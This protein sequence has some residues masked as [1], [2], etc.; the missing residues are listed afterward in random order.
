VCVCVC[1]CV[2]CVCVCVCVCTSEIA[3]SDDGSLGAI[4]PSPP[5]SL[6][7]YHCGKDRC[8][9]GWQSRRHVCV[10]GGVEDHDC[11]CDGGRKGGREGGREGRPEGGRGG[12]WEGGRGGGWE[13]RG[14]GGMETNLKRPAGL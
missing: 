7:L 8:E 5:P 12:G 4:S 11:S 2:V 10:W 6:S 13:G 1:V 9:R 14:N 3:V